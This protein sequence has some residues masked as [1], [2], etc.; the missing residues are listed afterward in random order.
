MKRETKAKE[1]KLDYSENKN[2]KF[3]LHKV[4]AYDKTK[5]DESLGAVSNRT[6]KNWANHNYNMK[7]Y[8]E[9]LTNQKMLDI[10]I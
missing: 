6:V 9:K 8:S 7:P 2:I 1:N 4:F 3:W 10:I 5:N